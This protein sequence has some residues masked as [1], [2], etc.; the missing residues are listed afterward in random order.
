MSFEDRV[1][2][3]QAA[4]AAGC[5]AVLSN[6]DRVVPH[7]GLLAVVRWIG[8]GETLLNEF[9]AVRHHGVQPLA[10]Q[11]FPLSETEVESAAEGGTSQS[12]EEFIQIAVHPS[13]PL[14]RTSIIMCAVPAPIPWQHALFRPR[15]AYKS[16]GPESTFRELVFA[17]TSFNNPFRSS[18]RVNIANLPSGVRDHAS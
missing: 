7:W 17:S 6:E 2:F 13:N 1:P 3:P 5:C 14:S 8:G 11:V 9:L 15:F 4:T 18:R 16:C 12:L 10:R